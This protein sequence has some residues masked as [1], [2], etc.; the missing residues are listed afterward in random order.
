MNG[1]DSIIDAIIEE[2]KQ[3][4]S[5]N[6]QAAE[7]E[8]AVLMSEAEEEF[9]TLE[10]KRKSELTQKS[11]MIIERAKAYNDQYLKQQLMQTK[12]KFI[13][14][15]ISEASDAIKKMPSEEYFSAMENLIVSNAHKADGVISF[16]EKDIANMPDGFIENLKI[17]GG[18]VKLDTKAADIDGGFIIK[19]GD[20]EENCSLESIFRFK[21]DRL[22][23]IINEFLSA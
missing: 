12:I 9:A 18:S 7:S 19:Y 23:D 10:K 6:M 15:V 22:C 17:D 1:L 5:K 8:K 4:A 21:Y 3:Q 14:E 2:A 20:I 11:E 13:Q 16:N